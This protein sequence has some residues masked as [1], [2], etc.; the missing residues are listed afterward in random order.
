MGGRGGAGG[1]RPVVEPEPLRFEWDPAKSASNKDKHGVDFE[2]ARAIW[3]DP[4]RAQLMPVSP[5][6]EPRHEAEHHA[7]PSIV[8]TSLQRRRAPRRADSRTPDHLAL[9]DQTK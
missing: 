8:V 4:D 9:H 2:E 5:R 1:I 6:S 3:Q 7:A